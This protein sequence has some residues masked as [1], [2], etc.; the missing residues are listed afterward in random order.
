[1]MLVAMDTVQSM[2]V[3]SPCGI[4]PSWLDGEQQNLIVFVGLANVGHS[5]ILGTFPISTII[6]YDVNA[7]IEIGIQ[8]YVPCL[9]TGRQH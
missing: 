8:T 6:P 9:V 7:E 1:M 4:S 5:G 2:Q 3:A